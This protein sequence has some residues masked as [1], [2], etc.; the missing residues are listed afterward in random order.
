MSSMKNGRP[1][2]AGC[3]FLTIGN[4]NTGRWAPVDAMT[5]SASMSAAGRSLQ[6]RAPAPNRDAS[7]SR[8][9]ASG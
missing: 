5:M 3:A 1:R 9:C 6:S 4:V 2:R 7:S 8:G